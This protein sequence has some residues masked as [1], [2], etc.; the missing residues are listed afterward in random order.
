MLGYLKQFGTWGELHEASEAF[1]LEA[2]AL[3]MQGRDEEARERYA[4]AAAK[5]E[6]V[7]SAIPR[8]GKMQKWYDRFVVSAAALYYKAGDFTAA[9]RIVDEHG[10]QVQDTHAQVRLEEVVEALRNIQ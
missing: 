6:E 1:A 4:Q 7:L 8:E 5:E 2:E 10:K 3:K 9:G